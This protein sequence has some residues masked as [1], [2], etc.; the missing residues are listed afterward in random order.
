MCDGMIEMTVINRISKELDKVESTGIGLKTCARL[1]EI[2][3]DGFEYI[4]GDDSF[5]I[6]LR[7]CAKRPAPEPTVE[8]QPPRVRVHWGTKQK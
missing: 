5:A 3:A 6:T 8:K 4:K 2:I 1:A 7:L